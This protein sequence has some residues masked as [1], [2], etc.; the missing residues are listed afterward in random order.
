VSE[1]LLVEALYAAKL[2]LVK[3]YYRS[4]IS[5]LFKLLVINIIIQYILL[6]KFMV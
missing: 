1:Y 2:T 4:K 5:V 6:R 3:Q